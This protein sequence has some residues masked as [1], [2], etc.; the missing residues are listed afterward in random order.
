[1]LA[2]RGLEGLACLLSMLSAVPQID[3]DQRRPFALLVIAPSG[4]MATTTRSDLYRTIGDLLR[5]ETGFALRPIEMDAALA[6]CQGQLGCLA[7]G[8]R[9]TEPARWLAIISVKTTNGTDRA[10]A[11]LLDVDAA[12]SFEP[13][14]ERSE[15]AFENEVFTKAVRARVDAMDLDVLAL[16]RDQFRP[17]LGEQ[18]ARPGELELEAQVDDAQ[19]EI[20][21]KIVGT[22]RAPSVLIT[23]L[24]EG[25]RRIA[26]L[27]PEYRRFDAAIAIHHGERARLTVTL[28]RSVDP[29]I[30]VARRATFWSGVGAGA[31]G[32]GLLAAAFGVAATSDDADLCASG[33][34]AESECDPAFVATSSILLGPLGY[35]FLILGASWS[36]GVLLGDDDSFP[37]IELAAGIVLGAAAYAISFALD[38]GVPTSSF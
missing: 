14:R 8:V 21:G 15:E 30:A 17:A 27:H 34:E 23:G 10:S 25:E 22:T 9:S 16:F 2:S 33:P 37:W 7:R 4:Q 24:A 38:G 1:M 18:W 26:V 36:I 35:S 31:V 20:D 13:L 6:R 29:S 3:A 32:V 11:V 5:E 28:D 19:V 12:T